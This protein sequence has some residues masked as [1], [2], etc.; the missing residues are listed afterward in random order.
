MAFSEKD[1]QPAESNNQPPEEAV[2]AE[3][4][5]NLE[6]ERLAAESAP[7]APETI[8]EHDVAVDGINAAVTREGGI[9]ERIR[10][11]RAKHQADRARAA[12]DKAHSVQD[13]KQKTVDKMDRKDAVHERIAERARTPHTRDEAPTDLERGMTIAEK[14]RATWVRRK[15]KKHDYAET[16]AIESRRVWGEDHTDRV[17]SVR[18]AVMDRVL[19][20]TVSAPEPEVGI[21]HS[22]WENNKQVWVESP[23]VYVEKDGKPHYEANLGDIVSTGTGD[24][25]TRPDGTPMTKAE[26]EMVEDNQDLI[27]AGARYMES[28]E[29]LPSKGAV[30]TAEQKVKN[31]AAK[32]KIAEVARELQIKDIK[33][34]GEIL[35]QTRELLEQAE[36]DEQYT[37]VKIGP[38]GDSKADRQRRL[39]E[40]QDGHDLIDIVSS[41]DT[42]DGTVVKLKTR[43]QT[44]FGRLWHRS[45]NLAFHTF[46]D[47][48]PDEY[49]EVREL[50]K[51]APKHN[52][53]DEYRR[54]RRAHRRRSESL[55]YATDQP[56]LSWWRNRRRNRA[57][58]K[59]DAAQ[60]VID[61]HAGG[62]PA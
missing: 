57:Q 51:A 49:E 42:P 54:V 13:R 7:E 19:H 9:R 18:K 31:P 22:F 60:R 41:E 14:L 2:N 12:V 56:I 48:T 29:I 53:N 38:R 58:R 55:A 35:K 8:E 20:A 61:K 24:Q 40:F 21:G 32:A 30:A 34:E 50:I 44:K 23:I 39:L 59:I 62:T 47:R 37:V 43:G 45:K 27:R 52:S 17:P 4:A 33:K 1:R 26:L 46:G 28:G 6:A 3:A 10:G 5:E 36:E 25:A 16:A 11:R 15:S